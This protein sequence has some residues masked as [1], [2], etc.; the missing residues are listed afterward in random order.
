M[1]KRRGFPT[2]EAAKRFFEIQRITRPAYTKEWHI[3]DLKKTHPRRKETR[4]FV[5]DFN[6]WR[7]I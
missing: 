3:Y 7:G 1:N 6:E 5:G 4:F 2:L